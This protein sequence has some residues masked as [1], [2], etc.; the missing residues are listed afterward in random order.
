[1][2]YKGKDEG[3]W[4]NTVAYDLTDNMVLDR[5][6]CRKDSYIALP[7][8]WLVWIEHQTHKDETNPRAEI[9]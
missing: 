1:M 5:A 4:E 7:R 3:Q 9:L 2:F 8:L 6:E